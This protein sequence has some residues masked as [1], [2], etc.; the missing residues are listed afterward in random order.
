MAGGQEK[1]SAWLD[2]T[3][4]TSALTPPPEKVDMKQGKGRVQ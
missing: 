4:P 3:A 2:A 1:I